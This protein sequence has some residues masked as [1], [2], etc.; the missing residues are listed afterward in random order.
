MKSVGMYTL[1][2]KVN[3][4]ETEAL[5][6]LFINDGY[7][8]KNFEEVADVYVINTCTVTNVAAKKSRQ[9][10]SRARKRNAD[11]VVIVVGCYAQNEPEKV[12]A[13]EGVNLIVGTDE[14]NTIIEQIEAFKSNHQPVNKVKDI[15]R[16]KVYEELKVNHNYGKTRSYIKIQDGCN[17]FCSYCIIPY[18]RGPIRSRQPEAVIEEIKQLVENGYK[19]LVL[20]GIHLAS[21]GK[22]LKNTSL[23]DIIERVNQIQGLERLR[24]GSLEPTMIT[25]EFVKGIAGLEKLCPH[26]HLS[27]QSGGNQTLKEM[28]RKYTKEQY[29]ESAQLLKKHLGNVALTTDIIV[30]FPGETEEDHK[31][32]LEFVKSIGFSEIHVFK[33]SPR[34]GTKAADR[35]DQIDGTV[36]EKRSKEMISL[37]QEMRKDYLSTFIGKNKKVLV[38]QK[39][40][41][42]VYVGYTDNY[43]KVNIEI[44]GEDLKNKVVEVQLEKLIEDRESGYSLVGDLSS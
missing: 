26:F 23:F 29:Y 16:V 38:E 19:E 5:T 18:T 36:K 24:L 41:S 17:Q 40:D 6:E 7:T 31:E 2:C 14:R 10:I 22:D 1:G 3:Q 20:T 37:G 11:A 44:K 35:K 27:L 30:G 32:S 8:I 33:Y 15:K 21:Y 34:E 39:I 4:Y 28:N 9:I 13:I 12:A 42:N 43:M 25:E